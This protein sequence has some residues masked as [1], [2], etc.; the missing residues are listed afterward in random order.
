MESDERS[1][2]LKIKTKGLL[3]R[4]KLH[5]DP[6]SY[7]FCSGQMLGSLSVVVRG[8]VWLSVKQF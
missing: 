3:T 4:R 5:T 6:K 7:T 2:Q 8:D 1:L